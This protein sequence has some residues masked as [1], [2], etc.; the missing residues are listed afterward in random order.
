MCFKKAVLV[1]HGFVGGT[2][3]N[4]HLVN[5][6]EYQSGLD[7]YSFTLPGHYKPLIAG[8]KYQE[9]IKESENQVEH[10]IKKYNTVY[11]VGHSMGGV[12]ASHLATK[13][14]Q[15]KKLVLVA[16]GFEYIS[17]DQNKKD[18]P[19]MNK[20]MDKKDNKTAYE[21]ILSKLLL[22]PVTTV[23]EFIKLIKKYKPSIKQV[24][25]P[26][27]I[28]HGDIDEVIPLKASEYA[29]NNIASK[30]K[31]LTILTNVRHAVF[32]CERNEEINNYVYKFLKGGFIWKRS[33]KSKY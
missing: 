32:R 12:I 25:I 15:I 20:I 8:V 26:T 4:E 27:L 14:P 11:V 33:Y 24:T 17:F 16:P 23:I 6:L 13:Y 30:K 10:L 9:W 7:V 1:I 21:V 28:L 18:I 22:V 5:Y 3:D 31:Y 29:Y 19:N 2:Y